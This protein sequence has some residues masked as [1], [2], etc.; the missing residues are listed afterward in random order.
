MPAG[1]DTQYHWGYQVRK[2]NRIFTTYSK[3]RVGIFLIYLWRSAGDSGPYQATKSVY[4]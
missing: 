2:L 4:I 3:R 1:I